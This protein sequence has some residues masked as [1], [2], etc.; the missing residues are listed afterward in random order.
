MNLLSSLLALLAS[1]FS[2]RKDE[3][4]IG[5][6]L[7]SDSDRSA[8]LPVQPAPTEPAPRLLSSLPFGLRRFF[9]RAPRNYKGRPARDWFGVVKPNLSLRM[10]HHLTGQVRSYH[11]VTYRG[12]PQPV[13]LC[14][15]DEPRYFSQYVQHRKAASWMANANVLPGNEQD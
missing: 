10:R 2:R 4:E 14:I 15:Q 3:P 12:Q 13:L 5:V 7:A 9:K 1:L 8:V 6:D 11:P